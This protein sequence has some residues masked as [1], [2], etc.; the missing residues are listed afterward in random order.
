MTLLFFSSPPWLLTEPII[1][2]F[3][4]LLRPLLNHPQFIT[5]MDRVYPAHRPIKNR[6]FLF[7]PKGVLCRDK[8]LATIDV[9]ARGYHRD[10]EN[11][12]VFWNGEFVGEF[13]A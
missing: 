4:T 6:M 12:I 7:L 8:E 9:W 2:N 3:A 13:V 1:F 5:T 10:S 11:F